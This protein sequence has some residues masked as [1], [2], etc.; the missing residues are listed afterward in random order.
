[1]AQ[2]LIDMPAEGA[3]RLLVLSLLEQLALHARPLNGTSESGAVKRDHAYME[4]LHRLRG[5][6]AVYDEVL[7]ASIPRRVRRRL[8]VIAKAATRMQQVEVQ[9]AWLKRAVRPAVRSPVGEHSQGANETGGGSDGSSSPRS[10]S[11]AA[12]AAEWLHEQLDRRRAKA[13]LRLEQAHD[14]PRPFRRLAKRLSVYTTAIRLDDMELS[15]SFGSLTARQ[16]VAAAASLRA[17]V[18]GVCIDDDRRALRRVRVVAD[19]VG[20]LLEPIRSRAVAGELAET[21]HVL[22]ADLARLEGLAIVADALIDGGRRIGALHMM[23]RVRRTVWP[24]V[25]HPRSVSDGHGRIFLD[26]PDEIGLGLVSLAESLRDE[27]AQAFDAFSAQWLEPDAAT[28]F[29]DIERVA[30]GLDAW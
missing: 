28:F 25:D 10:A 16:L 2:L 5:C 17:R 9:L 3:A 6:I 13:A 12:L 23:A 11:P 22:R 29:G 1:M 19:H 30:A 4:A 27:W 15:A 26:P 20:Y 21:V 14:D 18:A 24:W 7:D 8:R